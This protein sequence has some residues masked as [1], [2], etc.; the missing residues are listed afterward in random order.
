VD[1]EDL[2]L[3]STVLAFVPPQ[4]FQ[5]GVQEAKATTKAMPMLQAHQEVCSGSFQIQAK[6]FAG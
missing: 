3:N 2:E 6:M 5:E 1:W 4:S